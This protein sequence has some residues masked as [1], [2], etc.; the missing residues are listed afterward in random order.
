MLGDSLNGKEAPKSTN[1]CWTIWSVSLFSL[2]AAI[3]ALVIS[4]HGSVGDLAD[5]RATDL[6]N[7]SDVKAAIKEYH[8]S[9]QFDED[10]A[11]RVDTWTKHFDT[12]DPHGAEFA[13][14]NATVVFDVDETLLSNFPEERTVNFGYVKP[15]ADAWIKSGNATAFPQTLG[16]F[17][18]LKRR[19]FSI[20]IM[21][22]RPHT[23]QAAT[24]ANLAKQG[25]HQDPV[26]GYDFLVTRDVHELEPMTALQYKSHRRYVFETELG[27]R[28]VGCCGD[29]ISDC[30]GGYAGYKMKVVNHQYIVV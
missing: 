11:A 13:G 27:Y 24:A 26:S 5:K 22:G 7:L 30:A 2:L 14:V 19:G 4:I 23:Q 17:R 9:G 10:F 20:I 28:I 8:A 1:V 18:Y 21:T 15:Y 6:V 12:I 3:L 29:Q 16:F 25:M